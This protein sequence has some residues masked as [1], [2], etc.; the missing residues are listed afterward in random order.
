MGR[1]GVTGNASSRLRRRRRS[2][3]MAA[4]DRLPAPARAW[5]ARAV[6]PW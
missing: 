1:S 3:P 4:H 5:V 6:L 2:C